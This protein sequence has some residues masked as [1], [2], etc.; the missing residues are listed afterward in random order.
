MT[1]TPKL[2]LMKNMKTIFKSQMI[3]LLACISIAPPLVGSQ[4]GVISESDL[5]TFKPRLIGP[6]VTGGIRQG[7]QNYQNLE[8][9]QI[10]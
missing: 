8:S 5:S 6:A 2:G 10:D 4:S 9:T 1:N 7:A 3:A